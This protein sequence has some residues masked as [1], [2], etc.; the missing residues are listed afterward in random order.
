MN[1]IK[2]L[3]KSSILHYWVKYLSNTEIPI[4]FQVGTGLSLIGSLLWRGVGFNQENWIVPPYL[5]ILLVGPSG[6]G[7]DTAINAMCDVIEEVM[8]EGYANE[9]IIQGK[10]MELLFSRLAD[11]GNPAAAIIKAPE[12]T[13]L[14]GG[15]DYQKSMVQ[16]LTDLLSG[17]KSMDVSIKSERR[18]I[19]HPTVTLAAGS[20]IE[21]LQKA[22]PEGAIEGGFIPRLAVIVGERSSTYISLLR[23]LRDKKELIRFRTAKQRFIEGLYGIIKLWPIDQFQYITPTHEAVLLYDNWYQNRFKMF[24]PRTQDY[25]NRSRDMVLKVAMLCAISCHRGI[26]YEEDILFGIKFCRFIADGID[27]AVIRETLDSKISKEILSMLPI[28]TKDIIIK[29]SHVYRK[30]DIIRAIGLLHET[31]RI[32]LKDKVWGERIV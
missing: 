23:Y 11:L 25:A 7:K 9:R 17:N 29:L 13:A 32:L 1:L 5:S 15:K 3:P 28:S 18:Y 31:E 2:S 16:D 19:Q 27:M 21:W 8:G 30:D 12:L 10:T 24:S 22:M 26:I 14:L 20:T 6:C 4:G